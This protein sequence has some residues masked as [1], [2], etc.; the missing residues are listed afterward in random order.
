M[1]HL[2]R[3][4]MLYMI[5]A[6][7]M[8]ALYAHA[9]MSGQGKV[10]VNEWEQKPAAAANA[11]ESLDAFPVS[12]DAATL[13][14]L[15]KERPVIAV[16]AFLSSLLTAVMMAL[17]SLLSV[18]GIFSG[19]FKSLWRFPP[20]RM[21]SWSLQELGRIMLLVLLMLGFLPFVRLA[22]LYV[23][24]NWELD[25]RLWAPVAMVMLDAFVI[26]AILAFA[27]GKRKAGPWEAV[28]FYRKFNGASIRFGLRGYVTLFP[29]LLLLLYWIVALANRFHLEI[30]AEP[31]Q[32][33]IFEEHRPWVFAITVM[34]ACVLGPLA[35]ECFF[36]GV[37]YPALRQRTSR[38]VAMLISGGFFGA[39]HTN[40]IG[41]LPI[42]LLGCLLAYIY[43]R[44]GSL[45]GS[46]L[47]HIAHNSLLLGSAIVFRY[48][49]P[50]N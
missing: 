16:I 3:G 37:L 48:V 50:A 1:K 31:I 47:V 2:L 17:G 33:L 26:V 15:A 19:R 45:A 43:E 20:V 28:G 24:P 5:L 38:W 7:V 27:E 4:R 8:A 14:Q 36:R 49:T 34:L 23:Q 11:R 44:T 22:V 25:T 41:F 12:I 9:L 10:H 35:E 29:W 46:L 6:G 42:M 13:Q 30:P 39:I 40:L 21:A 18:W 32:E